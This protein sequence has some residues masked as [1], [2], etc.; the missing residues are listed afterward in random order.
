MSKWYYSR[1]GQVYGPISSKELRELAASGQLSPDDLVRREDMQEWRKAS[2]VKALFPGTS[3][4]APPLPHN[5]PAGN[6]D[7]PKKFCHN[8]GTQ[9]PLSQAVC[10]SCGT[11]LAQHIG[12]SSKK[13]RTTAGI[14]AL[15]LGGLGGHKF[16]LGYTK[17]AIIMLLITVIG[18]CCCIGPLVTGV[19]A[20][21]EAI[22]Y[23]KLSDEQFE[24]TY[25]KNKKPWF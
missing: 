18:A 19:I 9:V 2:S 20:L 6:A 3:Q 8:C 7:M 12:S 16:Y 14:L 10:P 5:S 23:L 11:S 21:I 17:E 1:E 15:F 25:V 24:E 4:A 13:S 22:N